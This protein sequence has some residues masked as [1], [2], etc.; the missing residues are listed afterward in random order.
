M[1]IP[2]A[3]AA[4]VEEDGE[5]ASGF[6]E[7]VDAVGDGVVDAVVA[8]ALA[9]D[10]AVEVPDAEA[11][12]AQPTHALFVRRRCAL[13]HSAVLQHAPEPILRVRVVLLRLQR[14]DARERAEHERLHPALGQDGGEAPEEWGG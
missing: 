11:D 14:G 6:V 12:A 4:A 7:E 3:L 13:D 9:A 1:A 2:F 5:G 10:L 8:G